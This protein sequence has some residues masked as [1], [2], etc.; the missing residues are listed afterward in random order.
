M[1]SAV[2]EAYIHMFMTSLRRRAMAVIH[3]V[4]A[5]TYAD[6]TLYFVETVLHVVV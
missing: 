6:I 3:Y 4:A 1:N 2:H 5:E